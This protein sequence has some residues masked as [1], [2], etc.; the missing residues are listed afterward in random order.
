MSVRS[1]FSFSV[2]SDILQWMGNSR[3]HRSVSLKKAPFPG[4]LFPITSASVPLSGQFALGPYHAGKLM[5]EPVRCKG[6]GYQPGL[7]FHR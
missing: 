5:D 2:K 1:F 6:D 7:G 4:C 3:H